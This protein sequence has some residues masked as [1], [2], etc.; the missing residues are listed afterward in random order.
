MCLL[1][2]EEWKKI[3]FQRRRELDD[4]AAVRKREA[5]P[6]GPLDE[7]GRSPIAYDFANRLRN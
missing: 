6:M 7:A 4:T 1:Q 2:E 3:D 5:G